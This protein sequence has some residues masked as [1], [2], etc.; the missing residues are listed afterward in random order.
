VVVIL[1]TPT[2]ELLLGPMKGADGL[3]TGEHDLLSTAAAGFHL[4]IG[5][6]KKFGD[7]SL[8]LGLS[9]LHLDV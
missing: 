4:L 5:L 2:T 8:A 7:C 6:S 9:I 3:V 1:S